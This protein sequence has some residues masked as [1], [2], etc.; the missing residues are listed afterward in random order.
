ML[1]QCLNTNKQC[2]KVNYIQIVIHYMAVKIY[3]VY[4]CNLF[5]NFQ[6]INLFPGPAL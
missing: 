4:Y 2:M 6:P 1:H 3:Q 5:P